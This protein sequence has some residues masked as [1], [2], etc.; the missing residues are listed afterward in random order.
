MGPSFLNVSPSRVVPTTP[1][2]CLGQAPTLSPAPLE[3]IPTG[4]TC[5]RII[6]RVLVVSKVGIIAHG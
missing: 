4:T 6:T 5:S 1:L 2:V 3:T